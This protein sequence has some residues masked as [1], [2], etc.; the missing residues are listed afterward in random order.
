MFKT[1]RAT[2]LFFD[3]IVHDRCFD[4]GKLRLLCRR[5]FF[6]PGIVKDIACNMVGDAE[7]DVRY[8]QKETL[9]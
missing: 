9:R 5:T 2:K 3:R 1:S 8:F 6:L 4:V 7:V